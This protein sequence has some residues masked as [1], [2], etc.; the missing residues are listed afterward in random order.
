M[1]TKEMTDALHVGP[2]LLGAQRAVHIL[3]D[4]VTSRGVVNMTALAAVDSSGATGGRGQSNL[5]FVD[6]LLAE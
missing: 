4:S 3:S 6:G 5:T 1:R 2:I